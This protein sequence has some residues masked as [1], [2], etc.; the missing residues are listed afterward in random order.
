MEAICLTGGEPAHHPD[1]RQLVRLAH[2][3]GIP[4]SVVTSARAPDDVG[5]L[6][7]IARLLTNITVSA[8]SEGAMKLGR[9]TRSA[10]SA[11]ATLEQIPTAD[12]VLHLT[13]W[14]LTAHECQDLHERVDGAGVQI[15]LSPVTLD[16][17]ARQR[18][19][20]TLYDY[21]AQQR[22]DADL[23]GRYFQLSSRFQEHLITLRAMQLYPERQPSCA[24]AA[25]YLSASGEIRRCP[26]NSSG[27]SVRA[28]RAEISRFLNAETRDRTTQSVR[29]SAAPTTPVSRR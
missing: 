7:D 13:Y 14:K 24:A 10:A 20:W 19:G 5:R 28:P 29:P 9:T 21:L 27:V 17:M 1:L 6:A 11:L 15:Q 26:Y 4:V 23:L 22:E 18:A 25:L 3:F 8:D 2:Q 16:D 12:R